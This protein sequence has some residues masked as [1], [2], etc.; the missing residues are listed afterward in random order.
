MSRKADRQHFIA[1]FYLKNFAEPMFSDKLHVYDMCK[2]CWDERTPYGV[3]WERRLFTM[4]DMQG[5]R[6]DEFDKFLKRKVEDPSAPALKKLATGNSLDNT[7]RSAVALFIALTATRSPE[8]MN[9][10]TKDHVASLPASDQE[11]L[12]DLAKLWCECT[13]QVYDSKARAEFMKPSSFGAIWLMSQSLRSRLLQWQWHFLST[14]RDR[15]FVTSDRPV[16]LEW[17][18]EQDTRMV[19]FPVSSEVALIVTPE[20]LLNEKRDRANEVWAVNRQTMAHANKFVAA[21]G[22]TFPGDEVLGHAGSR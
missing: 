17:D 15:P 2:Q 19:S 5:N 20:G 9:L 3:G 1:Q 8:L 6:T 16:F 10:M 14:P 11:E 13:G 22:E 7:E 18:R 21:C 4:I 12:D